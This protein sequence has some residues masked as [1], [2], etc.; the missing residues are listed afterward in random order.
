[1]KYP[2]IGQLRI[3]AVEQQWAAESRRVR[4][5]GDLFKAQ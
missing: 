4:G 3:Y 1:M 2:R 5:A